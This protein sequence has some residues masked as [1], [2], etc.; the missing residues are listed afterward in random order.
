MRALSGL[1]AGEAVCV[2]A[3]L[4]RGWMP[5]EDEAHRVLRGLASAFA[6]GR[7]MLKHD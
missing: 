2:L 3:C 4:K 6:R 1:Y 5:P 7:H